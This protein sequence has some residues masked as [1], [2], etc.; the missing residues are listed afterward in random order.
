MGL[1]GDMP[2]KKSSGG[3]LRQA[4]VDVRACSRTAWC[5]RLSSGAYD[6]KHALLPSLAAPTAKDTA[7]LSVFPFSFH[8]ESN[9][10]TEDI[11]DNSLRVTS[12][13]FVVH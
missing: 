12:C 6:N 11:G 8:L 4:A 3:L 10:L 9:L 1:A 5:I 13:P 2:N 7:T